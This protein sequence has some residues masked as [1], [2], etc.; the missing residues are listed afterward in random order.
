M[1]D[2]APKKG[3]KAARQ[4]SDRD[5][6]QDVDERLARRRESDKLR[7]RHA[8]KQ[9]SPAQ[10]ERERLRK[11]EARKHQTLEQ[12]E[13]EKERERRRSRTKIRPFMG[14]DG[15]GG[16]TD[17][18]GRQ[19]YLLMAASGATEGEE[20]ILHRDG[21]PPRVEDWL[22]FILSLPANRTLVAFFFSYDTNQILRGINPQKWLAFFKPSPGKHGPRYTYWGDYAILYQKGQ[23]LRVARV[24]RSGS[25]PRVLKGSSRTINEVFGFFQCAFAKAIDDWQ[26]GEETERALITATKA[27]RAEFNELTPEIIEYCQ[28]ECR[29]LAMLMNEF[30][31]MCSAAGMVPRHWRG[32]GW[33]AAALL[34][35]HRVPKRPLTARER[36]EETG[37][38]P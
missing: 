33:L 21:K 15:E 36:A 30:R 38:N 6:R 25:K 19:P 34:E 31:D 32:A 4:E 10:R 3:G 37:A 14:V 23:Y 9:Q 1:S 20:R 2:D 7:K 28:L 26:I 22:E 13:A 8:R 11:R 35:K 16:G 24:D 5:A 29:Y 17:A 12:R 27:Q 18:L